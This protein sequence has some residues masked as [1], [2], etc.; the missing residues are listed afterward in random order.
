MHTAGELGPVTRRSLLGGLVMSTALRSF[1]LLLAP[2]IVYAEAGIVS[3][4]PL[5]TT[6]TAVRNPALVGLWTGDFT[7]RIGPDGEAA[8]GVIAG[9][10]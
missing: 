1:L 2:L 6:E 4:H 8:Y 10:A 3:L 5:Y 9:A 7:I